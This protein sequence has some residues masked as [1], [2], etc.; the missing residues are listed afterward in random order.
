MDLFRRTLPPS[1]LRPN[2]TVVNGNWDDWWQEITSD[3]HGASPAKLFRTQPHLYTVVTFLARN[4]AQ[5]G[6]H[7]FERV[8]ETDRRRDRTSASALALASVDGT[9]TT[10]DLIFALVGDLMLY[11]RA[12]WFVGESDSPSGYMI[13]RLP[14]TWVTPG[15]SSAFEV[16]SWIVSDGQ[17]GT[18]K[19][20]AEQILAFTGYSP[21]DP[22]RGSSAV[23]ALRDTLREQVEAAM[24][25]QQ[26][27]KRGGRASAVLQRPKDAPQWSDNARERFRDDWYAK[28]TGR[29][30]LAGG[31]PILED[32]MTL[33]RIDFS[34]ADQQFVEAAKLSL[35]TV[36]A[37]FHVNPTMIGQ[38]DGANYSNVREFRKML[39]GDTL[40][41]IL[42]QIEARINTFLLPML[43]VDPA[44]HYVEFNIAEK[45]QGSF[46][47]QSA[48]MMS[49]TGAPWMLRSEAR[50]RMNL[51]AID[52]ADSL[53]VPLNV[54][55]GG[56]AS[57]V[58]SG[59]QNL[60][61]KAVGALT[62][63]VVPHVKAAASASH[64]EKNTQVLRDFFER[65]G[66]SVLSRLGAGA[67]DWWD[68]DRWNGELAGVIIAL[69]TLISSTAGRAALD[70]LGVDPDVYDEP[71]TLAFLAEA[72][73]VSAEE[74][75]STTR[76]EVEAADDP[77]GVF[78]RASTQRAAIA[79]VT[80]ATFAA[81]FGTVEAA[82][83]QSGQARKRWITTSRNPRDS[84]ASLSG[85]VRDL[86][87][88][89]SNGLMWPG[90][91]GPADEVAGCMCDVE[92]FIP[93]AEEGR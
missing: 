78:E 59:S 40:G 75:N 57:V 6:L 93:E 27:W 81:S 8:G 60:V 58:D 4:V 23:D 20:P 24:Y 55:V 19:V 5:L 25:R 47:E 53:V 34:A 9:M 85:E 63:P 18:I 38:N 68:E 22:L 3:V 91:F 37:A 15:K 46:E 26:T 28:Y 14:P 2:V 56:Q 30:P 83:Q 11:D 70:S 36:A 10:Y 88:P 79:A 89:F 87:E 76:T 31:T 44:T 12:Y 16:H 54:L 66:R 51:P 62:S 92:V 77:A 49:A 52:G 35:V 39:Y 42:A 13:R 1:V 80:I 43:G 69:Y 45:L 61:P 21:T 73:R 41:P 29:G 71:R 64:I 82:R 17:G 74:M 32:G 48:A 67:E 86:D 50:A 72:A 90:A 65:Q 7:S 84:H 33:N